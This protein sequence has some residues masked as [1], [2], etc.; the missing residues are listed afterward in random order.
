MEDVAVEPT[1]P[2]P[3]KADFEGPP[4]SLALNQPFSRNSHVYLDNRGFQTVRSG[5]KMIQRF[6]LITSRSTLKG[7]SDC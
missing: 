4:M 3:G 1:S 7:L 5:A 6:Y 2:Q